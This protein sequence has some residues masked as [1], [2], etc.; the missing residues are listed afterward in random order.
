[1]VVHMAV[2]VDVTILAMAHAKV[3]VMLVASKVTAHTIAKGAAK[4]LA[5]GVALL[6]A[7]VMVINNS[8]SN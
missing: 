2:K 3:L 7:V 5:L 1:M 8:Y 6:L 4:G